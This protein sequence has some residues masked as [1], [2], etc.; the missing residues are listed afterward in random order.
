MLQT[1]D[2]SHRDTTREK[3]RWQKVRAAEDQ[4]GVRLRRLARNVGEIIRAFEPGDPN[5]VPKLEKLLRDYAQLIT[6]WAEAVAAGML[7]DVSRRDQSF[8]AKQTESM[9]AAMRR[10]ILTAPTGA[11]L[12][13]LQAEQVGLI[14]SIPVEAAERVHKLTIEGLVSSA[15]AEEVKRD[16]LRTTH[17]TESRATLIARTEV[18]R[19]STNLA[20]ARAQHVGSEGYI[21]RTAED[22]D[23]R[24]S[25]RRLNGKFFKWS[26]P[27]LC[28]PPNYH[29]HPGCIFNCRCYPEIVLPEPY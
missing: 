17:V 14:K 10:E 8:W 21:W 18:G 25:H 7:A 26:S 22:S 29:A 16:L 11:T 20:Q 3:K 1:R 4:Y 13:R 28:D 27:P 6:P 19:A 23:V 9:G 2:A 5:A 15:R 24:R 12:M